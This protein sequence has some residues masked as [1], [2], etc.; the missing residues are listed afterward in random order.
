MGSRTTDPELWARV[1]TDDEQAFAALF[2]RYHH[3]VLHCVTGQLRGVARADP[4]AVAGDVFHTVWR[5][6]RTARVETTAWPWLRSVATRLCAN[7]RR[8]CLRQDRLLHRVTTA[9]GPG[10]TV[11]PDHAPAVADRLAIAAALATLGPVERQVAHL[12]LVDDLP[13]A[14]V[15]LRLRVPVGTVKSRLHR[16]RRDLGRHL[17]HAPR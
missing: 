16:A 14:E 10:A 8:R 4:S 17:R 11:D 3:R 6:R 9:A 12:A 2:T 15:A 5:R 13:A 1:R 7:E